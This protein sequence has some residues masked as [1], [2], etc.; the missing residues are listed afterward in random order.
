MI[1]G[2]PREI[3]NNEYRVGLVPAGVHAFV[4]RGHKVLIEAGAGLGSGI[5]DEDYEAA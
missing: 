4:E 2:V 1:V 5:P 3:K